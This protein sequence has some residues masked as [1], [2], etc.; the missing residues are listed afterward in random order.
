MPAVEAER[1]HASMRPRGQT[2]RMQ[3]RGR[4]RPRGAAASM[5]PRGQT[6]RMPRVEGRKRVKYLSFNEAAGADPADA[7]DMKVRF[8][9]PFTASMR[10]RGQTPRM[11]PRAAHHGPPGTASMRPRG[12]TPRMPAGR[13]HRLPVELGASMRPRGQT[14]RM[15]QF[16]DSKHGCNQRCFNEAAGADPADACQELNGMSRYRKRRLQ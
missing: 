3:R 16:R 7:E 10:P 11:R 14:P 1:P 5:R 8:E 4:D 6:P 15:R 2:P 12:Q 13:L 9:R